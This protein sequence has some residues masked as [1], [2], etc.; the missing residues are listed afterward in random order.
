MIALLRLLNP[1]ANDSLFTLYTG[2]YGGCCNTFN[3]RAVKF[4]SWTTWLALCAVFPNAVELKIPSG[5]MNELTP[6]EQCAGSNL[7]KEKMQEWVSSLVADL[8]RSLVDGKRRNDSGVMSFIRNADEEKP[9]EGFFLVS[10]KDMK[11]WRDAVALA[12]G[13][14]NEEF[15]SLR[16][17]LQE[18]L[19]PLA[20]T[21]SEL[22]T[23]SRTGDLEQMLAQWKPTSLICREHKGCFFDILFEGSGEGGTSIYRLANHS[24][25]LSREDYFTVVKSIGKL[26]NAT[27]CNEKQNTQD[28]EDRF[29]RLCQL[30]EEK[31]HPR[32]SFVGAADDQTDQCAFVKYGAGKLFS[33]MKL[34]P[35]KCTAECESDLREEAK[36]AKK[37][38]AK[39]S[40]LQVGEVEV[41]DVDMDTAVQEG[42]NISIRVCAVK[43]VADI[44]TVLSTMDDSPVCTEDASTTDHFRRRSG[45]KRRQRFS[46]GVVEKEDVISVLQ[47]H[48]FAALRLFLYEK[49][50]SFRVDHQLIL[51]FPTLKEALPPACDENGQT[52]RKDGIQSL[53]RPLS[54]QIPYEWNTKPLSE[55]LDLATKD[56]SLSEAEKI[57]GLTELV[58]IRQSGGEFEGRRKR[59]KSEPQQSND[60]LMESLLETANLSSSVDTSLGSMATGKGNSVR[61]PERGFRGTLL[62][63]LSEVDEAKTDGGIEGEWSE[64]TSDRDEA[65]AHRHIQCESIPSDDE[66][67]TCIANHDDVTPCSVSNESKETPATTEDSAANA[68]NFSDQHESTSHPQIEDIMD[69]VLSSLSRSGIDIDIEMVNEAIVWARSANP[70]TES[71]R[72]IADA[73]FAK[74]MQHC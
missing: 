19:F 47:T 34:C 61:R 55:A 51:V 12:G 32:L 13:R 68:G 64:L 37:V 60:I 38:E 52:E 46:L 59:T 21:D 11:R 72:D 65:H 3:R 27:C 9:I 4:V 7:E 5:K 23:H 57:A 45:R 44:D 2:K 62:S 73:A 42:H 22:R 18:I 74:C 17:R 1:C 31:F 28:D 53:S 16:D 25:A 20:S 71:I 49:C 41:L 6:C 29:D 39:E 56:M 50:P 33:L 8:P 35:T 54:I 30:L 14:G 70:L 43:S 15:T 40:V 69:T 66:D 24:E 58:L 67:D 48:N 26:Y 36:Y 10:K 63:N